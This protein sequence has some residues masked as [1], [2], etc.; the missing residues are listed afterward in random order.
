M[1]L[2]VCVIVLCF[3]M[4]VISMLWF[5]LGDVKIVLLLLRFGKLLLLFVW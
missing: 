3:L 2:V 4:N 5:V 1:L